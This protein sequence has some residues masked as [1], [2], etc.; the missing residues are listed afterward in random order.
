M[1]NSKTSY[2][3]I[4]V[5]SLASNCLVLDYELW[6]C[7][8]RK[9]AGSQGR[10]QKSA[11]SLLGV[12]NIVMNAVITLGASASGQFSSI[13]F[14]SSSMQSLSKTIFCPPSIA[15]LFLLSSSSSSS[16]LSLSGPMLARPRISAGEKAERCSAWEDTGKMQPP[17][18]HARLSGLPIYRGEEE[19]S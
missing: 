6:T 1:L 3:H 11:Q 4:I 13:R 10:C 5:I 2:N 16:S 9:A 8:L 15:V 17:V 12:L 19:E 18:P 7:C 14:K